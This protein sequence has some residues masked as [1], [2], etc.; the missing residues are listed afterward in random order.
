[1]PKLGAFSA[2]KAVK[3]AQPLFEQVRVD[4]LPPTTAEQ[5]GAFLIVGRAERD[6]R[7]AG[8]GMAGRGRQS[9]RRTRCTSG[10]SGTAPSS[11]SCTG[12]CGWPRRWSSSS[13]RSPTR[14]CRVR[15]GRTWTRSAPTPRWSTRPPT[16]DA[17]AGGDACR[18]DG[19][20]RRCR[21]R[22]GAA[23]RGA[24]RA[25]LRDGG[26]AARPGRRTPRRTSGSSRLHEVADRV[27]PPRRAGQPAAP[28]RLRSPLLSSQ[29][30]P[31]PQW[32]R[33]A[34]RLRPTAWAWAATGA[35]VLDQERDGRQR[36][37]GRDQADRG[38]DP[39]GRSRRW[40][41]PGPGATRSRR[42]G[43]PGRPAATSSSTRTWCAG[44]ARAP[45]STRA[46]RQA[47]IR[48]GDGP[49]PAGRA[50]VDHADLP[51]RRAAADPPRH[52]RRRDRRRGV[53][54]RAGGDL[55]AV[56]RPQDRRHRRRQA[57]LARR[58]SASTS[59]SCA[60][61]PTSTWPTTRTGRPGRTRSAACSTRP[62]CAT[63]ACSR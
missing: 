47:E 31:S 20:R 34:G 21:S 41:R 11:S 2:P 56:P 26:P 52:V 42:T 7:R 3:Q 37:A 55:P 28:P 49:L 27:A 6:A 57:G 33:P 19:S 15:T 23:G 35:W 53:A 50:G 40:R 30:R 8:P 39:R 44:S 1:M 59:S 5:V 9:R 48:A 12:C 43:S 10:C 63:A 18:C 38:P 16:A 22:P 24:V 46:Q 14:A 58:R 25:R 13:A 17:Y 60:T 45:A 51:D 32:A 4:G 36:A 29:R 61:S 62:R 54:G